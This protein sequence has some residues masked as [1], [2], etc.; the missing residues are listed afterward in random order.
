[1]ER[2]TVKSSN[3]ASV[4]YD[5]VRLILEIEFKSGGVYQYF[6]VPLRIYTEFLSAPSLGRYLNKNIV[7]IFDYTCIGY[8]GSSSHQSS[9]KF[10]RSSF[11]IS[12]VPESAIEIR[13]LYH[14]LA[15]K[16]HPDINPGYEKEMRD[17]NLLYEQKN[18]TGLMVLAKRYKIY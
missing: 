2:F 5:S 8:I 12:K 7:P 1:M 18:F 14:K 17:T 9:Y 15:H 11:K 13:Q 3:I 10:Q 4:G 6:K 16:F